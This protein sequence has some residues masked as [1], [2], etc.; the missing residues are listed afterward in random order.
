MTPAQIQK[1]REK[2]PRAPESFFQR[3]A[4]HENADH[5]NSGLRP[6]A[7]QSVE[8]VP[9]ENLGGSENPNWYAAARRFEIE[10]IVHSVRPADADGYS[11]KA[12]QDFCVKI[13][14]LPEDRWDVV[15]KSSI[16]SRK[17]ATEGEERTEVIISTVE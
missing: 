14:I 6:A 8:R 7:G 9:L 16:S 15:V 4:D 10:F 3:Q 2:F 17:A 12:C 5:H 11:T 1:L 13:G